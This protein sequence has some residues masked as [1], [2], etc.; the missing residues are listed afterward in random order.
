MERLI[1]N[2]TVAVCDAINAE[3]KT[4]AGNTIKNMK[5]IAGVIAAI[6]S[7]AYASC[8]VGKGCPTNGKNV[9]AEKVLSGDAKTMKAVK[10]ARKFRA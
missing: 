3:K 1:R 8:S 7:I 4:T 5:R 6:L 9:G 2:T 10:K